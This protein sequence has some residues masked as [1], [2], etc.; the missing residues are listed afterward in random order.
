MG[1][2]NKDTMPE[3]TRVRTRVQ[4]VGKIFRMTKI[5]QTKALK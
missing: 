4:L 3:H 2:V 1:A 5:K